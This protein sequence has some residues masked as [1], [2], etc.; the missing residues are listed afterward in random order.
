M[1]SKVFNKWILLTAAGVV[2]VPVLTTAHHSY[3]AEFDGTKLITLRGTIQ[4][5]LWSSPHGHMWIEVKNSEGKQVT[6]ELETGAPTAL[7][8]R[9]WTKEDLP[10]GREVIVRGYLA[11]DGTPTLNATTVKLVDTGRELF[12]GSAETPGAPGDGAAEAPAQ[13]GRK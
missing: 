9:G 2:L 13:P 8:R 7:Y 4:R 6:W 5:M 3:S 10:F 1:L 11:K 12:A